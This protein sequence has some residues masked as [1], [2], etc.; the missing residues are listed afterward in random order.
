MPFLLQDRAH[1]TVASHSDS[2]CWVAVRHFRFELLIGLLEAQIS[3]LKRLQ[4][5]EE[6]KHLVVNGPLELIALADFTLQCLQPILEQPF[7]H[8]PV[9]TALFLCGKR[10]KTK[11]DES[12]KRQTESV[13]ACT[14]RA[15]LKIELFV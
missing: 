12:V 5:R 13:L 1:S 3:I 9:A 7:F 14:R 15:C 6:R 10:R 8:V 2:L 11:N 4:A